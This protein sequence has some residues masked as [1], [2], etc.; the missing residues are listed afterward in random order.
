MTSFLDRNGHIE[1]S[2]AASDAVDTACSRQLELVQYRLRSGELHT[3]DDCREALHELST[4][5]C[6]ILDLDLDERLTLAENFAAEYG[7]E[8]GEITLEDVRARIEAMAAT[9]AGHLG[10]ERAN[11]AFQAIEDF[12]EEKDLAFEALM[13]DN[14]YELYRHYAERDEGVWHVYEYRNLEENG[15][16]V[17][18]FEYTIAEISFYVRQE[19]DHDHMSP[20][21]E[22]WES[23]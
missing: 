8:L 15:T 13:A 5:E 10:A 7:L 6:L 14:P 1:L 18:I 4:D 9:I 19:V 11:D 21:E 16:H 3:I 23:A 22:S 2:G 12:L 20:E 17:D